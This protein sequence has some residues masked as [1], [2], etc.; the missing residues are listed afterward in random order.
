MP[1]LPEVETVVRSLRPKLVGR[2]L[3]S[4]WVGRKK[5]REPW[6]RRWHRHLIGQEVTALRRRAK[7]I[8]IDLANQHTLVAHLGMTGRLHVCPAS[9]ELEPHT[10]FRCQLDDA[11]ELRFHDARRFGSLSVWSQVAITLE[12]EAEKLGPEPWNLTTEWLVSRLAAT[13]R[14]LKA[15]LLDQRLF[16]GVGNIYADE[17]LFQ[18]KLAPQRRACEL[19]RTEINRLRGAVVAVLDRAIARHGTTILSFYYGEG[20]P[21]TYQHEFRAYQR[22]GLPCR[23]CRT[24]IVQ[25]RLAGRATHFCPKCQS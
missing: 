19:T 5:L 11:S 17:S 15:V 1:E 22:T 6:Q 21:G 2:R 24:L 20:E 13:N 8:L 9:A 23:R 3:A 4:V 12:L 18:A 25:T 10:H 16:A 7:W 14:C